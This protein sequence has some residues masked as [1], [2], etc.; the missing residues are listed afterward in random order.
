MKQCPVCGTWFEAEGKQSRQ[1]YCKTKTP[2]CARVAESA[3]RKSKDNYRNRRH[4]EGKH[5]C[6]CPN[7]KE[8]YYL[9]KY[10]EGMTWRYCMA[11]H[12]NLFVLQNLDLSGQEAYA[13][14]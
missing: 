6:K 2:S 9:K 3:Q 7:C 12:Q 8:T 1:K 10:G 5:N 11:C 13:S 14:W 4:P